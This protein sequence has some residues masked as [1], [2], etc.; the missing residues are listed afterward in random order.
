[1]KTRVILTVLVLLAAG[2]GYRLVGKG[3]L[4]HGAGSVYVALFENDTA[5]IG[6][7]HIFTND[8]IYEFTRNGNRVADQEVADAY[9]YGVINAMEIETVSYRGQLASLE[10]RITARVTIRLT[11][12]DGR[13]LWSATDISEDE[14]YGVLSE[15]VAT[16]FNK[17][18][19]IR[20]VSRRLAENAYS[21]MSSRF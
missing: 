3:T 19:A 6:V 14:V 5:E 13:V 15:K 8:M 10:R 18:E 4:P 2:C 21:R 12:R 11:D 17:R 7:S 20:A 1:M 16:D 9:L